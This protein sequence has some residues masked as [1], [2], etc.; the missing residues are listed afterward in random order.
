MV[1]PIKLNEL[2]RAIYVHGPINRQQVLNE[3]GRDGA[4]DLKPYVAKAPGTG[5]LEDFPAVIGVALVVVATSKPD[6]GL[7]GPLKLAPVVEA[8]SLVPAQG[9]VDDRT[10]VVPQLFY[11]LPRHLHRIL[12]IGIP[13]PSAVWPLTASLELIQ[14]LAVD[15]VFLFS[16]NMRVDMDFFS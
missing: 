14:Q 1:R 9:R 6:P 3:V 11:L 4:L 2:L 8:V 12:R 16:H 10:A 13:L 15:T 7:G 5:F